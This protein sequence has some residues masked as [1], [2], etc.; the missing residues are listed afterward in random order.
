MGEDTSPA[1]KRLIQSSWAAGTQVTYNSQLKKWAG[2]CE[3]HGIEPSKGTFAQAL[4]FLVGLFEGKEASY[5][6]VATARSALSSILPVAGDGATFGE[7]PLVSRT[8]KGMFKERPQLPRKV[9]IYD[10]DI[11]LDFMRSLPENKFLML[12]ML[13]KKLVT[14]LCLLSGQRAQSIAALHINFKHKSEDTF[15]FYIPKLIKTST[16]TFH[17]EPLRVS[18]FPRRTKGLYIQLFGRVYRQDKAHA[19]CA[20]R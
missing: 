4:D 8:L 2:Y 20:G 19:C 16:P 5:S 11:V 17:Q 13:T 3:D 6:V 1:I 10:P 9:V 15:T 14:L 18:C 7:D 12:E